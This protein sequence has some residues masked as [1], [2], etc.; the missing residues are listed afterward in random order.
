MRKTFNQVLGKIEK[1]NTG[2]KKTK[3]PTEF[4]VAE[5]NNVIKKQTIQQD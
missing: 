5:S 3:K 1:D 2:K 4:V